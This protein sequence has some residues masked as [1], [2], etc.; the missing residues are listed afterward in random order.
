[1]I[2]RGWCR[3]ERT[4]QQHILSSITTVNIHEANGTMGV[5]HVWCNVG[6]VQP[7]TVQQQAQQQ[8]ACTEL[9][10]GWVLKTPGLLEPQSTF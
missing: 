7:I 6:V 4:C 5:V 1:V 10:G 8:A 3:Q 9:E 2:E